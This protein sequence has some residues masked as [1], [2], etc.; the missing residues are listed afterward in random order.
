MKK[1]IAVCCLLAFSQLAFADGEDNTPPTPEQVKR[2]SALYAQHCA[3]CHGPRM[4]DPE[5]A[6]DLRT[7]P[8]DGKTRFITSVTHGKASMPPWGGLLSAADIESLWGYV[9]AG[10]KN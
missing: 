1:L 2:G 9:V 8:R 7:F 10:E 4:R 5:G 6:F 3:P